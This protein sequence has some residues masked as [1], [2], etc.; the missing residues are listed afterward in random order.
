MTEGV[1]YTFTA[2]YGCSYPGNGPDAVLKVLAG[3]SAPLPTEAGTLT[4]VKEVD[5]RGNYV[6]KL[7]PSAG[8]LPFLPVTR[9]TVDIKGY[10]SPIVYRYGELSETVGVAYSGGPY[11]Q[12]KAKGDTVTVG[13]TVTVSIAGVATP[14][15]PLSVEA[16]VVCDPYVAPS[17]IRD[18]G[19]DEAANPG[20]GATPG[21][22][23]GPSN[24]GGCTLAP[25]GS[26]APWVAGFALPLL[27]LLLRR[28][29]DS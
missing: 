14:L 4:M 9:Y 12:G 7:A 5:P 8:L 10:S 11:C 15:P 3:P 19:V 24:A 17:P 27:G 26:S 29:R 6:A 21:S 1:R 23:A 20:A 28:R 25:G 16:T 13:A 22:A 18:A 2:S